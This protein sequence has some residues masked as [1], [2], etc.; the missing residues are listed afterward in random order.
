MIGFITLFGI[1]TRNGIIL[2][3]HYNQLRA[4]GQPLEDVV[5]QGTL[6]RLVPVLMT[7]A[8]AALGLLPLMFGS[9][10]GKELELP[11][12]QV[13]VGGLISATLLNMLIVPTVYYRVERWRGKGAQ[14]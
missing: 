13:V 1:A 6:D 10:V 4:A 5:I 8:T 3:S 14:R 12:A 11:L 2:V 9:P 7:A